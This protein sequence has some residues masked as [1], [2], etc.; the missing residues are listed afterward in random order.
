MPIGTSLGRVQTDAL[1]YYFEDPTPDAQNT[2]PSA[3]VCAMP[4]PD[5]APGSYDGAQQVTLTC[6]TEGAN[7]YYTLDGTEPTQ[8]SKQYTGAIS[9][10]ETGMIRARAFRDGYIDS[11]VKT[12]TYFIGETHSLP[13]VSL[14]TDPDLLFDPE[15]GIYV[16][17]PDPVL[18]KD[19]TMHYEE[20]NYLERG[21][22]SERPASFE[23]FD[24]SGAR[25]FNQDVAIR[26]QGGFSRDN[27][28][29][30]FSIMAR[31]QYGPGTMAYPFFDN[32]PFTEYESIILRQGGQ[33]QPIAKIKEAVALSLVEGQGF[34]FIT[35]ALKPYVVY[36]N[37]EYWGA[38]FMMEKRSEAFIAQHEGAEDPDNMN[39]MKASTIVVQGSSDSYLDLYDYVNSH[40]MSVKENY[41]YLAA[42]LDTDSFMDEM[43]CEIWV[44][45]SDYAN[46]E[47]YQILPDGKWK[48][49]YYD[50]CWTFGS[51]AYPNGSHPTLEKRMP[52]KTAGSSMFKALLKYKP[53][54]D[55]FIERFAWALKEVYNPD[56]VNAMID[57][58]AD[59]VRDEIAA[60]R[61]KFGGTVA[62]WEASVESMKTF[63]NHR[64][65]V[66]VDHLKTYFSLSQDQ[67]D[68]LND[69]IDY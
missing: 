67:I 53:W 68:M 22:E 15:T 11:T 30:S 26:I 13:I 3:G 19:S 8:S 2:S 7:I 38:Y 58:Y 52:E 9:I 20:A 40:D 41:D 54:R 16:L 31:S 46:M 12:V 10:G 63:T 61:E 42:R 44:A 45:N 5:T 48:Q 35:Q 50:F 60:E 27:A 36:I 32:R 39:I 37:G 69:A 24:E 6:S 17:G 47:Y 4:T 34:N 43:I 55:A 1:M 28:Q 65:A 66:V 64:G 51:S 33:D 25:V 56:R 57:K 18:I 49:V 14:V 21:K 29:K 62:G 23:V 59:L